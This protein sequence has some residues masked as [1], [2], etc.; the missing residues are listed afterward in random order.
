MIISRSSCVALSSS[1][2]I[3]LKMEGRKTTMLPDKGKF[4]IAKSFVLLCFKEVILWWFIS[5]LT[6]DHASHCFFLD[7]IWK[8]VWIKVK[9]M[10]LFQYDFQNNFAQHFI[11]ETRAANELKTFFLFYLRI[12][13]EVLQMCE[14]RKLG[15]L[16][17]HQNRN[18]LSC[19]I[20]SLL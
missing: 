12:R 18:R 20:R 16:Q 3:L 5:T 19:Q 1:Q 10:Q 15:W 8:S 9:S 6:Q 2:P 4:W 11:T 17:R 13:L 7:R 14:H